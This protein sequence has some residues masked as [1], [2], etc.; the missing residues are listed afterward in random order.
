[1]KNV[2]GVILSTYIFI[3]YSA[4]VDNNDHLKSNISLPVKEGPSPA[5][6]DTARTASEY[7]TP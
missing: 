3:S 5:A 2:I 4:P 6:L 1:M 7:W